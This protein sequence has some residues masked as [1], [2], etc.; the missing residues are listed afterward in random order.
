MTF[1][2]LDSM[3][4][5]NRPNATKQCQDTPLQQSS[6]QSQTVSTQDTQTPKLQNITG[7]HT[8]H[9]SVRSQS[10][11]FL[12][13]WLLFCVCVS[14]KTYGKPQIKPNKSIF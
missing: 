8:N 9:A 12:F 4:C 11:V 10:I 5:I 14:T 6:N 7:N 1:E 3:E 2:R 13:F